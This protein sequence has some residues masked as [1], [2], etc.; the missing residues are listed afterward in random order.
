MQPTILREATLAGSTGVVALLLK[1]KAQVRDEVQL[2]DINP[3]NAVHCASLHGHTD[4]L[5]L[6]LES[7]ADIHSFCNIWLFDVPD[8]VQPLHC[9]TYRGHVEC[10][11]LLLVARADPHVKTVSRG[12]HRHYFDA[13]I[14]SHMLGG[15]SAVQLIRPGKNEHV[16]RALFGHQNEEKNEDDMDVGWHAAE[17]CLG[18]RM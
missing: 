1:C 5:T 9:A 13:P 15:R 2:C 11:K 14:G 16:L 8:K 6:L 10:V 4:V 18:S 3:Y 12:E 7:R 17:C